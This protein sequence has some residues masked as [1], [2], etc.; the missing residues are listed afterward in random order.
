MAEQIDPPGTDSI[1]V[2][3]AIEVGQPYAFGAGNGHDG[4]GLMALHLG[5]RV[6]DGI[7]AALQPGLVGTHNVTN[8]SGK[9]KDLRCYHS[10]VWSLGTDQKR[11]SF[12][13]NSH[14]GR[15]YGEGQRGDIEMA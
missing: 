4:Q 2:A 15:A 9:D 7:E 11:H 5:A 13:L 12:T 14:R 3:L 6:P 10:V 1:Q 8:S